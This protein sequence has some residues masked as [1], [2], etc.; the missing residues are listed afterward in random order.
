MRRSVELKKKARRWQLIG[1]LAFII[2]AFMLYQKVYYETRDFYGENFE[3]YEPSMSVVNLSTSDA[4]LLNE[5]FGEMDE[6]RYW[7]AVTKL[8]E[9]K[10]GNPR[11][12]QVAEWYKILCMIRLEEKEEAIRLLEYYIEQPDFEFNRKK[13]IQLLKEY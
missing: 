12:T 4:S 10:Q 2:G 3:V 13:A 9:L 6:E 8:E 5:A 1:G 11:A 7:E